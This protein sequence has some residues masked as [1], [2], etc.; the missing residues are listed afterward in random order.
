MKISRRALWLVLTGRISGSELS[1]L[2][3]LGVCETWSFSPDAG[4]AVADGAD[5]AGKLYNILEQISI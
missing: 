3:T 4:V 5:V 2:E 1:S